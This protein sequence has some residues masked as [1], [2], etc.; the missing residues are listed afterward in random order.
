MLMNSKV[1]DF[2]TVFLARNHAIFVA[3]SIILVSIAVPSSQMASAKN[4]TAST[5]PFISMQS[6]FGNIAVPSYAFLKQTSQSQVNT[7]GGTDKQV[8]KGIALILK[9][10]NTILMGKTSGGLDEVS[11]G[12]MSLQV[13]LFLVTVISFK[14]RFAV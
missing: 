3:L 6:A 12:G 7:D 14:H 13:S 11:L 10:V 5:S 2:S 1:I 4:T 8:L 9:G